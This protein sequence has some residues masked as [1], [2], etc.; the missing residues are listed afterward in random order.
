MYDAGSNT[1]FCDFCRKAGS[2]IAGKT[3]FVS[4]SKTF[5]KETLKKHGESHTWVIYVYVTLQQ[6]SN[7]QWHKDLSS[8][9]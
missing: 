4:G 8:K 9:V 2:K 7:A 5:K 6:M 1:M 3:D